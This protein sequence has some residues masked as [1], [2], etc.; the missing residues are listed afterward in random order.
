M[1]NRQVL[2]QQ[3]VAA[4][5]AEEEKAN[6]PTKED[7]RQYYKQV[8]SKPKGKRPTHFDREFFDE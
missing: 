8:R 4:Q 6:Q 7:M 3:R 5:K 2:E 1:Y